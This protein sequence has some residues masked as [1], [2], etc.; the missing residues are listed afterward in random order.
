MVQVYA[1]RGMVPVVDPTAFV[2]PGA[3]LIGDVIIGP[4]CYVA[5]GAVLRA[6]FGRI[7]LLAGSNMQDNCVAHT[8]AGAEMLI[9]ENGNIGHGAVLHGC[10]VGRNAMVG[11]NAVVLDDAEIGEGAFVGAL[12][13]VPKGKKVPPHVVAVGAPVRIL[14]DADEAM[15]KSQMAGMGEYHRMTAWCHRT[16]EKVEARSEPE[17]GRRMFTEADAYE[18]PPAGSDGERVRSREAQKSWIDPVRRA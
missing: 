15:L 8:M 1:Y 14:K 16:M 6:D 5:P 18:E 7:R 4:G 17:P 2:H 9:E 3:T 12:A 11:M 10:R 13:V